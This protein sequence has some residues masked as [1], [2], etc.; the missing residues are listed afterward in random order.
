MLLRNGLAGAFQQRGRE[1]VDRGVC[2]ALRL[3][4]V[5]PHPEVFSVGSLMRHCHLHL[6]SVQV[7]LPELT[8]PG[9]VCRGVSPEH[10]GQSAVV[11][12]KVPCDAQVLLLTGA[13]YVT[14]GKQ[15]PSN[16]SGQRFCGQG[17]ACWLYIT[18]LPVATKE[19]VISK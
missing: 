1:F 3:H 15:M 18:E 12:F 2:K 5:P 8:I 14:F 7:L 19:I 4:K 17:R 10:L 9:G 13:P 11:C 6:L 16:V